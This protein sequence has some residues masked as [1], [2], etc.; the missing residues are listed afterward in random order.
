MVPQTDRRPRCFGLRGALVVLA[1]ALA[2]ALAAC[3]G[4][5]GT[6]ATPTASPTGTTGGEAPWTAADLASIQTD[7]ELTAAL[8]SK[9]QS[10]GVIRCL[11]D[12]PYPPWEYFDPPTSQN[13]AGFDYEL[14]QALCKKI[15]VDLKF[16]DTPFDS[17]LL[18]MK[19]GQ[20]DI[21][22]SAMND[23]AERQEAGF[24]WV[25][26]SYDGTGILTLK[27]NPHDLS[28]PKSLAGKPVAVE[29]GTTQQAF[30][31]RLNKALKE[32]DLPPVKVIAVQSQPEALLAVK[33]NRA[34]ADVT[35]WSTALD[36]AANTGKGEVFEVIRDED[37]PYDPLIT[38]IGIMTKNTELIDVVQRALQALIDEG[39]YGRIVQ[40][41]G[42][43][44]V[45]SAEVN[46]GPAYA[47]EHKFTLS[48]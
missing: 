20:G 28:G 8:P 33:G 4:D 2:L 48:P 16:I 27:G 36:I 40:T 47:E 26:Y 12:I 5:G 31:T 11:S 29:N 7:P 25:E 34:V 17:I 21:I 32:I 43:V 39:S 3:G 24:S 42:M 38:G 13:P 44:P 45:K 22:L 37:A 41:W 1:L 23:T 19:A 10:A 30:L 15:G 6:S 9:I 46:V 18:K 35:D 14:A